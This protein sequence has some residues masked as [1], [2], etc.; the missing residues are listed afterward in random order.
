MSKS[1][2]G[3]NA[4]DLPLALFLLSAVLGVWPAYDRSLCWNMLIALAVAHY[5]RAIQIAP[6]G[7]TA[8]QWH[9]AAGAVAQRIPY[10]PA[11]GARPAGSARETQAT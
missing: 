6:C 1:A 4:L 3:P 2:I 5:Q 8:Q 11:A 9:P 7:R 10:V